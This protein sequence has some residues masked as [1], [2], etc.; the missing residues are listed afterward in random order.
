MSLTPPDYLKWFTDEINRYRNLEW[1]LAGYS[2]AISYGAAFLFAT[3]S[4]L[5]DLSIWA[6][7]LVLVSVALLA[8]AQMHTHRRLNHYRLRRKALEKDQPHDDQ[9]SPLF[10]SDAKDITFLVGFLVLPVL[11]A[12]ASIG[13]IANVGV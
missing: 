3:K 7:G 5:G 8:L 6:V 11:F 4:N 10:D 13:F 12:F 1:Q 9:P 2:L